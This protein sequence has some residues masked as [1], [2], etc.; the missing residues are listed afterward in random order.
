MQQRLDRYRTPSNWHPGAPVPQ[1][2]IWFCLGSPLLSARWLPGSAWRVLLLRVFGAR[3]GSGCRIKPG[4]RVKFPWRLLVGEACWLAEDAWLDNLAPITLGDRV[5]ISQ[6]AY[7]CTGNHDFRSP[8]F[9]LRLGPITI[10]SNAWIAA[11][12]VLAPG[13]NVGPGAVVA[14]GAV[15]SGT[16]EPGSIV[17]GNPAVVVGHR[18]N[19]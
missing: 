7:L 5:C 6:G 11:C 13:T 1:Q 12:A 10:G 4:L 19:H 16:V 2:V 18:P 17:R 8:G 3:I 15:V 9:E 14:L